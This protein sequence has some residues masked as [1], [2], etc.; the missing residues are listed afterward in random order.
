MNLEPDGHDDESDE[1]D[2]HL[3]DDL[4]G[5]L[6]LHQADIDHKPLEAEVD[7]E[8]EKQPE[9]DVSLSPGG[10]DE[11]NDKQTEAVEYYRVQ[12]AHL[13]HNQT[14]NQGIECQL[15]SRFNPKRKY[16]CST[17]GRSLDGNRER[18]L[19]SSQSQVVLLEAL[20]A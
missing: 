8:D 17:K 19:V 14:L 20:L 5:L 10:G 6:L 11:I 9:P 2:D 15:G 12:P 7:G 16:E 18:S 4:G 1:A 13:A 3:Q